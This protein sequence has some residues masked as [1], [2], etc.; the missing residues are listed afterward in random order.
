[1]KITYDV[2]N[3]YTSFKK[4]EG[5]PRLLLK[6]VS[7]TMLQKLNTYFSSV[8]HNIKATYFHQNLRL[9]AL[10]KKSIFLSQMLFNSSVSFIF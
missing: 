8:K 3:N 6:D 10:R 1:M 9:F 7:P 4:I 2:L 5:C